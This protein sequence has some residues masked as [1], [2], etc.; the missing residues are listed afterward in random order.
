MRNECGHALRVISEYCHGE[1]AAADARAVEAHLGTCGSC[2]AEYG[3]LRSLL[4]IV[5]E[6]A[7]GSV[8]DSPSL[9][10]RLKAAVAG[11]GAGR[12]RTL[13]W[14]RGSVLAG[15]AAAVVLVLFLGLQGQGKIDA[16][17]VDAEL[18]QSFAQDYKDTVLEFAYDPS[19][20][21]EYRLFEEF[22]DYLADQKGSDDKK[23]V[24][25]NYQF[26]V[27]NIDSLI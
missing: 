16:S 5:A 1:L 9:R 26:L 22:Y 21:T 19:G 8:A 14:I 27:R 24:R 18:V 20:T 6:S 7:K 11:S 10:A 4:G 3:R 15:A 23:L 2:A 25:A 12:I 17:L 13:R